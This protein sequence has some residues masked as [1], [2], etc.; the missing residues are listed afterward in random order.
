MPLILQQW[1][2]YRNS[3]VFLYYSKPLLKGRKSPFLSGAEGP[4]KS[5]SFNISELTVNTKTVMFPEEGGKCQPAR[6]RIPE[7]L[8]L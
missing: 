6:R 7:D 2:R 8:N 5:F 1:T 3:K 4:I